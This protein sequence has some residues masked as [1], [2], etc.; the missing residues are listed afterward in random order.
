[1]NNKKNYNNVRNNINN[2]E[3]NYIE[4]N[5]ITEKIE[6]YSIGQ[7]VRKYRKAYNLSQEQLAEQIGISTT[8]L[9]HI[10]TGNTKLSL[11]VLVRLADALNVHTDELLYEQ[12]KNSKSS[13]KEEILN[14]LDSCSTKETFILLD[15]LKSVKISLDKYM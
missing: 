2:M 13:A 14:I 10:E 12:E 7:R 15:I 6:Y 3:N 8:H 9:S 5:G 11:P 4:N 1:M